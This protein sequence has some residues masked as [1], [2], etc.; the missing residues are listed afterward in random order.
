MDVDVKLQYNALDFFNGRFGDI[1][2]EI[3]KAILYTAMDDKELATAISEAIHMNSA[4]FDKKYT[5][6]ILKNSRMWIHAMHKLG[7]GV[8]KYDSR[9]LEVS[10]YEDSADGFIIEYT[11]PIHINI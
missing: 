8:I 3:C 2:T 11:I 10:G 7:D 6:N 1:F 5:D 9:D 4:W